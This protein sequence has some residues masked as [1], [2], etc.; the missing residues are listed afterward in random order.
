MM[1]KKERTEEIN[2]DGLIGPTHNFSGLAYGNIASLSSRFHVSSPKKAA[3]QGLLKMRLIHK[4]GI[5]QAFIPP[6]ERPNIE[7]LRQYGYVG[8]DKQVL[9]KSAQDNPGLLLT[10]SSAS[11]MWTANAATI[12]PSADSGDSRVHI[13]TANLAA[14]KHRSI[15]PSRTERFLKKIFSEQDC[16]TVHPLL[17]N[18]GVF[19]DEG[20]ANHM[21]LSSEHGSL[22]LEVFVYGRAGRQASGKPEKYPARQSLEASRA[23]AANH[24]LPDER[25]VYA[26]QNPYVI[27]QGV[28]HNDVIAA[29]N[30]N[31]FLIHEKALVDT[32][33]VIDEIQ[34]KFKKISDEPL[35]V[36]KVAEE[37]LSVEQ[38]VTTYFFNNQIVTLPDNTMALI[39]PEECREQ[40][41]DLIDS[42]IEG[43]NP[44]KQVHFVNLQESM[45]NGGGPACLR[46]RVVLTG[47][48]SSLVHPG[49]LLGDKYFDIMENWIK[50]HYRD[51]IHI[52]DL[53]DYKLLQESREA[54]DE[55]TQIFRMGSLYSF[56]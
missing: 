32:D 28:F 3:L 40:A 49:F 48:E 24:G 35:H 22:G 50:K 14:Q 26:Q 45:L 34:K 51:R 37:E 31:V 11:A 44:V 9:E 33:R 47:R 16:F 21:R 36:I 20:A 17:E 54:L 30:E 38:A 43:D 53:K 13:T 52:D 18:S 19:T 55:L 5:K 25:T 42:I 8:T 41:K 12:S 1:D 10:C 27:D 39:A 29:S 56:Q 46:L 7:S 15:E 2:F 4:L 6:H 23:V